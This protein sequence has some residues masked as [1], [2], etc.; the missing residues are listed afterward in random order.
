MNLHEFHNCLDNL[1]P[2]AGSLGAAWLLFRE[3]PLG[4]QSNHV[5]NRLPFFA[6]R[7]KMKGFSPWPGR[8]SGGWDVWDAA[9]RNHTQTRRRRCM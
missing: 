7:A 9:P 3:L 2:E 5:T 4:V 1:T 6:F 8:V